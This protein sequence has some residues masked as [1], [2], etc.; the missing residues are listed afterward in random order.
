MEVQVDGRRAAR[1]ARARRRLVPVGR[2]A[3][4]GAADDPER[5]QPAALRDA[6]GH[7]GGEEEGD[8]EG[9][10]AAGRRGRASRSSRSTSP[11]KAKKTQMIAGSP[12]EAAKELVR[13]L[14]EEARVICMILVIAEQRD[15]KLNRATLGRRSPRRSSWPAGSRSRSPCSAPASAPSPAELAAADVAEVVVVEHAGAR[16]VHARRLR[17]G[18]AAASIDAADAVARAAAAHLPD[19][20]LRADARRAARPRAHH[21]RHRRSRPRTAT[22]AFVAADVPGQADRRR[23]AAGPGAAP[24]HVPDRRVP[25]RRGRE[26]RG[27][28]RRCAALDV[29]DRRRR[30]PPEARGAVPGSAS[31]PSTC[32]RPSASSRSAAA[33][34]GRST[35]RSRS[36]WPRR[37]APSSPRRGRSATPAGCRWSARSAAPARPSRRSST[38]RSASPAPSSTWSA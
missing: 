4:A 8:P 10:A 6:Q 22:A 19:A 23:R 26:G 15:G 2:D 18:A 1:E 28:A 30:D 16:A 20:R 7:H 13:R 25:R 17:R 29:D 24:R 37:S 3:A 21:R 11:E 14:R 27:A 5:H 36:S 38:S 35:C 33:S 34:R 9:R 31:R 32:R 12:A